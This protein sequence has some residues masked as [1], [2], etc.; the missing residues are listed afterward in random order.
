LNAAIIVLSALLSGLEGS[1]DSLALLDGPWQERRLAPRRSEYA[2]SKK[3][4]VFA[5]SIDGASALYRRLEIPA[6]QGMRLG[7]RWRVEEALLHARSERTRAGD[8]YAARVA[9]MFDGEPFD[10]GTQALM[11]VWA[12]G[13]PIGASYRSPY[14]DNVATV[15]LRNESATRRRWFVET[16]DVVDDFKRVFG[17]EPVRVTAVAIMVDTDNTDSRA[18]TWFDDL[19]LQPAADVP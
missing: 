2:F 6:R 5:S 18:V 14:N 12:R 15:V 11:Y 3:G 1:V 13:E 10:R 4:Q 16:R 8:D 19:T 7:W 9:V 17:K